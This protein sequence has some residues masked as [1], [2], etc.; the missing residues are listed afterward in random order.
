MTPA[1]DDPLFS[2]LPPQL[3]LFVLLIV[4]DF[5]HLHTRRYQCDKYQCEIPKREI[6]DI[7]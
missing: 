3:V 6:T 4:V 7:R 5:S 1:V 2:F